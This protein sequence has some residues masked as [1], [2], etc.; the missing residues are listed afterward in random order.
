MC[1]Y[2][3][4]KY[5]EHSV[6]IIYMQGWQCFGDR[7]IYLSHSF[8]HLILFDSSLKEMWSIYIFGSIHDII[9]HGEQGKSSIGARPVWTMYL[10]A[11]CRHCGEFWGEHHIYKHIRK[12]IVGSSHC[13]KNRIFN[14]SINPEHTIDD[15][16]WTSN[17]ET[18]IL[19]TICSGLTDIHTFEAV[20]KELWANVCAGFSKRRGT[21]FCKWSRR[22]ERQDAMCSS[23]KSPSSEMLSQ[24]CHCIT[25]Y[26]LPRLTLQCTI[27]RVH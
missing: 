25:W 2:T 1:A 5:N 9:V 14:R 23:S 8:A 21:I 24:T 13:C 11:I 15:E 16:F 10:L 7:F 6:C 12:F 3:V 19:H 17:A 20:F 4:S 22:S 26:V 27:M 18:F